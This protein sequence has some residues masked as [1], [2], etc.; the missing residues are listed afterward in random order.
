M[1]TE[2]KS[3]ILLEDV[4]SARKQVRSNVE[5]EH[6]QLLDRLHLGHQNVN[7]CG[8]SVPFVLGTSI[9]HGV[10]D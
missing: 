6:Y 10:P 9:H 3:P 8:D 2:H 5:M 4:K 1:A 7:L